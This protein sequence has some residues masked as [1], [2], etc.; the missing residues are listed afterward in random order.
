VT[1]G[2]PLARFSAYLAGRDAALRAVAAE[3]VAHLDACGDDEAT[4]RSPSRAR[5]SDLMW[6]WTLGAYEV[7]RTMCQAQACFA[8]R[9]HRP[10]AALKAE[11]ERVRVP[12]TKLERPQY[13]RRARGV[14][15][16][17]DRAPELWVADGKDILVGDP[18][19]AVSARRLLA[20]Y[21]RMQAALTA[22]DVLR[23]H[24]DAYA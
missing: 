13:D 23:R 12:N 19:D 11:L 8:A 18:A 21:A 6:L 16:R 20:S 5:A 24:E 17:S 15:V 9:V 22:G 10:L 3:I 4:A 14:P 1:E 2:P 7:V